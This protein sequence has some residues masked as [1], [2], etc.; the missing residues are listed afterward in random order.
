MSGMNQIWTSDFI[1][2]REVSLSYR[3]PQDMLERWGVRNATATVGGRNVKLFM[4]GDYRGIDPEINPSANCTGGGVSCNF[5]TS[6]EAFG[7][8]V[9]RRFTFSLR[10]GF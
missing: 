4:F 8:P 5:L 1:R 3:L 2:W 7:V 9:P 6:T 10:V